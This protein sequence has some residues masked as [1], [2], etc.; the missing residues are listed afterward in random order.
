MNDP[1]IL[2]EGIVDGLEIIAANYGLNAAIELRKNFYKNV[3]ML[4]Q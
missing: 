3:Y 4:Q 1:E 2:R